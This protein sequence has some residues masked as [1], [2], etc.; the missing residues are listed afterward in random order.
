MDKPNPTVTAGQPDGVYK[1]IGK[2]IFGLYRRVLRI[3]ASNRGAAELRKS[4]KVTRTSL[5]D[6]RNA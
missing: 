1:I 3:M 4:R 6:S 5:R 2:R